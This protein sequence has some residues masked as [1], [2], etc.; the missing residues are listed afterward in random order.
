VQR[1]AGLH[2]EIASLLGSAILTPGA[3]GDIAAGGE[4]STGAA[5]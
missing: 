3:G 2:A 4:V 1:S 5:A